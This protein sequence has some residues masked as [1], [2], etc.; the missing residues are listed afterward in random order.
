MELSLMF[1]LMRFFSVRAAEVIL[2]VHMGCC[3]L[4][5]PALA[6]SAV[7]LALFGSGAGVL[8]WIPP[9]IFGVAFITWIMFFGR[10]II[11]K[12]L[13]RTGRVSQ[14]QRELFRLI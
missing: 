9:C 14:T 4:L 12:A 8:T 5:L 11:A 7:G 10:E 6:I 13:G 3:W 1:P 2:T